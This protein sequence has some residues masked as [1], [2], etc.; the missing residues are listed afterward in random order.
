VWR[1]S[2][3]I[4]VLRRLRQEDCEF[5]ASLSYIGR[6]FHKQINKQANYQKKKKKKTTTATTMGGMFPIHFP[7]KGKVILQLRSGRGVRKALTW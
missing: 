7:E 4:Q 1:C 6:L 3:V 2:P 5:E